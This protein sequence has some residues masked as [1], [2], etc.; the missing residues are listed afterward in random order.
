LASGAIDGTALA[1][2]A[3]LAISVGFLFSA[4]G[5]LLEQLSFHVYPRAADLAKLIAP[6]CWRTSAIG[7]LSVLWRLQGTWR[8]LRGKVGHWGARERPGGWPG[9]GDPRDR[10]AP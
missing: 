5:L 6:R 4:N 1:V 9:G 3:L 2:F 10:A 7:Q 8:W